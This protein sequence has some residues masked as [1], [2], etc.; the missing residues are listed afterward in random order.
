LSL[1]RTDQDLMRC[2]AAPVRRGPEPFCVLGAV[3][4]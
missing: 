4:P 1:R 3:M 2:S